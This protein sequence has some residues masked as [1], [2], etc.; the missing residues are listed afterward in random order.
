MK[1]RALLQSVAALLALPPLARLRLIAQAPT[2][3]ADLTDA[4][5]AALKAIAEVVLPAALGSAGRDKTV[6]EFVA[7]VRNYREGADRGHSYGSSTV[8]APTPASPAARYPP[9]FA[10]L[11]QAAAA[12]GGTTFAALPV[13]KRQ[14]VIEAALNQPQAVN[15][16]PAR[17]TG[18]NLVADFMGFFFNSARGFDL[19]YNAAIGR[20]SCRSLDGSDRAPE[21]LGRA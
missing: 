7:W 9:Q 10:A 13:V 1:R 18:A 5:V 12:Q 8:S 20:D 11:D 21:P 14:A 3:G 2:P 17:P 19:A 16:L 6:A 4:N 15:R